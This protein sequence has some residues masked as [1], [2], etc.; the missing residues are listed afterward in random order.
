MNDVVQIDHGHT[1]GHSGENL[2]VAGVRG[3]A[4][5]LGQEI[6]VDEQ[7]R[8]AVFLQKFEC[9]LGGTHPDNLV[10]FVQTAQKIMA[11]V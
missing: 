11:F 5:R 8:V 2:L 7:T 1:V 4:R 6:L 9:F 10:M 3:Q